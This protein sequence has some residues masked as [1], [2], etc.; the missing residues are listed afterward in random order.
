MLVEVVE[1]PFTYSFNGKVKNAML[2][3]MILS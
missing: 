3:V 1:G 2:L